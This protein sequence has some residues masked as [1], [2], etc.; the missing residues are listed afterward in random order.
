MEAI[1][2]N[3]PAIWGGYVT[4]RSIRQQSWYSPAGEPYNCHG[5]RKVRR[6]FLPS[7]YKFYCVLARSRYKF[8]RSREFIPGY[9]AGCEHWRSVAVQTVSKPENCQGIL[10]FYFVQMRVSGCM[11]HYKFVLG[12]GAKAKTVTNNLPIL[13]VL[14]QELISN[15][16]WYSL[17]IRDIAPFN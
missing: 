4:R 15:L 17:D 1:N 16:S 14:A 9:K 12:A 2:P 11:S 6:V 5:A 8:D 13:S 7:W 3:G 10:D